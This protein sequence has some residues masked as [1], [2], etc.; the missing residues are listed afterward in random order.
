MGLQGLEVEVNRESSLSFAN[1]SLSHLIQL[2]DQRC[3]LPSV[4]HG[5]SIISFQLD[6]VRP[7]QPCE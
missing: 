6:K 3:I 4:C 5:M 2:K 7:F 1:G